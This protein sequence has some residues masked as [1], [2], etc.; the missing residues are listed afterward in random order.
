M[1]DQTDDIEARVLYL[2]KFVGITSINDKWMVVKPETK[3]DATRFETL[4]TEMD[5]E[6]LR[7]RGAVRIDRLGFT[8]GKLSAAMRDAFEYQ[9]KPNPFSNELKEL[10]EIY[11]ELKQLLI[12]TKGGNT[13]GDN[14]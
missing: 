4:V 3:L 8:M 2:E 1:T 7:M 6:T 13:K 14:I 5:I 12:K 10:W 11:T 9:E